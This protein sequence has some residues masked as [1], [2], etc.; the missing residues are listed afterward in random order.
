MQNEVSKHSKKTV[1]FHWLVGLSMITVLIMG[2]YMV[3]NKVYSLY[4]WHRSLGLSLF[5]F[6]IYRL[7]LRVKEGL[8]KP[9][10]SYTKIEKNL[11]R[12]VQI[13]LLA[14]TILMP[15]SG[16]LMT[17]MNGF[18]LILFDLVF[19][20]PT[21]DPINSMLGDLSKTIH[22]TCGWIMA[23]TLLLHVSG[24]MKHHII[25]RDDTLKSMLK[26]KSN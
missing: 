20:T 19:V 22:V 16:I 3:E 23:G 21:P 6:A 9:K 18:G 14:S 24:A 2:M 17:T 12:L 13:L 25:D 1:I 26:L 15:I 7:I 10:L 4:Y 11:S 5:I 8:P